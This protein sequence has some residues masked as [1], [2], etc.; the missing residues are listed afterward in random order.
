MG[1]NQHVMSDET[2]WAVRAEGSA[3]P[4]AVFKTQS[5]AW[6]RAKAI[7][8]KERSEAILYGRNGLVRAR[9]T[10]GCDPRRSKA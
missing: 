5:D 4:F 8:R 3:Q 10:Y 7:A 2:G 1:K 6:E 9:S